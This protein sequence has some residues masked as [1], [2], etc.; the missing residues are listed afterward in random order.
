M[1]HGFEICLVGRKGDTS[2]MSDY[3]QA[4]NVIFSEVGLPSEKP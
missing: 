2:K 4:P 1:L 3:H